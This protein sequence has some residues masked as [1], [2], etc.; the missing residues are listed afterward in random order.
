[1]VGEPQ[2]RGKRRSSVA[3]QVERVRER[4]ISQFESSV[5][6]FPVIGTVVEAAGRER[7]AGGGLLAGG[8]AY[9]L[10]FWLVPLGLL[11]ASISSFFTSA[12]A[13]ALQ[14][15]AHKRGLIGVAAA[16]SQ[17]AIKANTHSRWFLAVLGAVFTVWF[18][19]GVVRALHIAFGLAWAET[20][21]KVRNP[22]LAGTAFTLAAT[23]VSLLGASLYQLLGRIGLGPF[24]ATLTVAI[25]AAAVALFLSAALEHGAAPLRALLPGAL[26]IALGSIG[27]HLAVQL[28][29]APKLGRSSNTYGLLG[30][31]TV[32]LLWLYIAARLITLSA[33]LNSTLWWR[34]SDNQQ[35]PED[36]D[37]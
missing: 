29:L 11:S 14:S 20:P 13:Q 22:L 23:L 25:V 10:F 27:V 21:R 37:D 18:G 7:R 12:N 34:Q 36:T 32:I 33:F 1:M 4:S 24:A 17:E 8:L 35:Q 15:A 16:A 2:P 3:A 5:E 30:A 26:L 19:S 28:Y 6:R 31:A 9:R